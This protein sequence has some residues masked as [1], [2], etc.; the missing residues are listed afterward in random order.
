MGE[1][2]SAAKGR[3][4]VAFWRSEAYRSPWA[5]LT[6]S[7]R[8]SLGWIFLWAGADKL[9]SELTT[10]KLATAG[11]LQYATYGPLAPFF[12]S[13]AGNVA[14]DVLLVWGLL[15]IGVA[16][17][18]GVFMRLAAISGAVMMLLFYASA[19]PPAHNPFLDDHIVY[20][21]VFGLLALAGAGRFLGLDRILENRAF[22][23]RHPRLRT[24]L[25]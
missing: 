18:L 21:L 25:G 23:Q 10:G 2:P 5:W 8:L 16:L 7:L 11:Y 19:W 9:Y 14:V 17:I 24:L 15:L 4:E 3:E 12:Q 13:L 1:F 6:F 20:A 22:V